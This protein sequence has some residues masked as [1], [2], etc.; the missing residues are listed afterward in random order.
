MEPK[1]NIQKTTIKFDSI[2]KVGS[3]N[4][5]KF[6]MHSSQDELIPKELGER[7]FQAAANPK[8]FLLTRGGHND[9]QFMRILVMKAQ[10]KKFLLKNGFIEN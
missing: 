10:L 4:I 9:G 2:S 1:Q 6:F 3:L 8:E 5:P 7:L